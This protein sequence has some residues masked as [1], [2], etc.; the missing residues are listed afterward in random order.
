MQWW[1]FHSPPFDATKGK[2]AWYYEGKKPKAGGPERAEHVLYLKLG[3]PR[4]EMKS[5]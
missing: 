4:R 5:D 1:Y 3:A 2:P